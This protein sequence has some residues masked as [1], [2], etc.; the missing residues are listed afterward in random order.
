[1]CA[2]SKHFVNE[3]LFLVDYQEIKAQKPEFVG[4]TSIKTFI[5]DFFSKGDVGGGGS[6][7]PITINCLFFLIESFLM[8]L[9]QIFFFFLDFFISI[10]V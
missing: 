10:K 4:K 9:E 8:F 6:S 7:I 3:W 5:E 2:K 1:M